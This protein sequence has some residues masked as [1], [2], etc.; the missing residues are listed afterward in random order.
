MPIPPLPVT[1]ADRIKVLKRG[2]DPNDS[3]YLPK[4]K[5]NLEEVIRMYEEGELNVGQE[6]YLMEGRLVTKDCEHHRTP[7]FREESSTCL[8]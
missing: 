6:V 2:L 4:Q 3:I 1:P 5:A 8:K 7:N